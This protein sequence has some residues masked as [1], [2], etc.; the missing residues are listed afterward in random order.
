[1]SPSATKSYLDY[2]LRITHYAPHMSIRSLLLLLPLLLLPAISVIASGLP[3]T[4]GPTLQLNYD[5]QSVSGNP[6]SEFMYFVPLLSEEVVSVQTRS[7]ATQRAR[8][9]SLSRQDQGRTFSAKCEFEFSGSGFHRDVFDH[10]E[11]IRRHEAALKQGHPLQR[12]LTAITVEGPGLGLIEIEGTVTN[13]VSSVSE[14][15]LRFN[16][17]G[18]TSPV[19][20]LLEDILY[21]QDALHITNE[22]VARVNSLTFSRKPGPPQM[23]VTVASVKHKDASDNLWQNLKGSLTGT[24]VNWFI[25][26]LRIQSLGHA[27][28][29]DFGLALA[30]RDPAFTF[31]S[32]TNLQ[33]AAPEG[34]RVSP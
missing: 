14:I 19:S 12:Q 20:I 27:T 13:G 2:E 16:A 21:R 26:P 34:T 6:I 30:T 1:M 31:P 18:K 9:L 17:H 28:M 25:P 23:E 10:T 24:A 5:A 33:T 32:A 3:Q 4:N 8:V 29:L 11:T 15:H 7:N 22:L